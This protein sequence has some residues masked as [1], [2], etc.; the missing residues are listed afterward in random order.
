MTH[1]AFPNVEVLHAAFI[2]CGRYLAAPSAPGADYAAPT[3]VIIN[4]AAADRAIALLTHE[5]ASSGAC[6]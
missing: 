6:L 2:G 3:S 4:Q 1:F 5:A